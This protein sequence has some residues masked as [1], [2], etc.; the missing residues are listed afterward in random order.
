MTI[1]EKMKGLFVSHPDAESQ[2]DMEQKS[3]MMEQRRLAMEDKVRQRTNEMTQRY[4]PIM[5]G[6]CVASC[7]H[8]YPGH[9]FLF[10]RDSGIDALYSMK[11]PKCK[12]WC[13]N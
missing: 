13:E 7:I 3:F 5:K 6:N 10:G 12:L 8:F 1:I 11:P 9:A 4:C 2:K